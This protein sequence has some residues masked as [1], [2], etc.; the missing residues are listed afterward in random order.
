M[1]TTTS[2]TQ[3]ANQKSVPRKWKLMIASIVYMLVLAV[4]L[5]ILS[6]RWDWAMAWIFAAVLGI[7]MSI[8]TRVAP[9]DRAFIEERTRMKA[10][11]KSWDKPLGL[12][13]SVAPFA[14]FIVAGLD[15]RCGFWR[16]L[17]LILSRSI[18]LFK[19]MIH[20]S[21]P[22]RPPQDDFGGR[23]WLHPSWPRTTV[24]H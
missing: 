22:N 13:L 12:I 6:G 10:D 11:V 3:Q 1:N 8:I 16:N 23:E 24:Y 14:V 4:L 18:P 9:A 2:A 19:T 7:T 15:M 20:W 21:E 5:A 17:L